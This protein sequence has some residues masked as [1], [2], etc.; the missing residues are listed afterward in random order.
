MTSNRNVQAAAAVIREGLARFGEEVAFDLALAL[1][2]NALLGPS[3]YGTEEEQAA[4]RAELLRTLVVRRQ[5]PPATEQSEA[6]PATTL[7]AEVDTWEAKCARAHA[8]WASLGTE[9]HGH[10]PEVMAIEWDRDRVVVCIKAASLADWEFWL[11]AAGAPVDADTRQTGYAQLAFGE[12]DG[13]P[14]H[15]VAHDVP[16]LLGE[17][18]HAA[19]EPYFLWGRI[20]DLACPL[21]DC[22]GNTWHYHGYRAQDSIPLL[23]KRDT[24]EPC[25]LASVVLD[26]GPLTPGKPPATSTST[27]VA[28]D[29]DTA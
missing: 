23:Q 14:V 17:A 2:T 22:D 25:A 19:R 7:E 20:Y 26:A 13:V 16:R 29:G 27:A 9:F 1:N 21:I 6:H 3:L 24:D 10:R 8:V 15:L 18:W 4:P 11:G 12:R 28:G 5:D